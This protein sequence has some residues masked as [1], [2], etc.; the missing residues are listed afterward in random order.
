MGNESIYRIILKGLSDK[1][2]GASDFEKICRILIKYIYPCYSFDISE[3]GRGTQDGGYD[4]RDIQNNIKLAC[5]IEKTYKQKILEEIEKSKKNKDTRI[6]F[7]SNQL[8]PER[9]KQDICRQCKEKNSIEMEIFGIDFLSRKIESYL[10]EHPDV[11]LGNLLG[12]S[13][14]ITGERYNR[15]EIT[16]LDTEKIDVLYETKITINDRNNH[17]DSTLLACNDI[18]GENPL[19]DYIISKLQE[20]T[21]TDFDNILLSGI[22]GIGKSLLM[23][24]T[25]NKLVDE[26]SDSANHSKYSSIPYI[27]FQD[28]KYYHIGILKEKIKNNIECFMFFLDGLDEIPESTKTILS[29]E[30]HNIISENRKIKFVIAG[31]NA[32]FF[33]I[34]DID[35]KRLQIKKHIGDNDVEFY[36][37]LNRFEGTSI[38]DLL[39]VPIYRN[40]IRNHPDLQFN[41]ID[42]LYAALIKDKLESDKAKFDYSHGNTSRMPSVVNMLEVMKKLSYFCLN[43]F[44]ERRNVFSESEL[45]TSIGD[46]YFL[47]ILHSSI[48]DYNDEENINFISNFYYEYFVANAFCEAERKEIVSAFFLRRKIDISKLDIFVIFLNQ[49]KSKNR[50][51]YDFVIKKAM[52]DNIAYFLLCDFESL[53]DDDR[54]EAFIKILKTYNTKKEWIYYG[55]SSPSYSPLKNIDNMA[56]KMQELLPVSKQDMII[57][58]MAKNISKYLEHPNESKAIEFANN[59]TLLIPWTKNLWLPE[60]QKIL[61]G[62]SVPL[63]RFLIYHKYADQLPLKDILSYH[64][65]F[66][67]WYKDCGWTNKWG[68]TS[69]LE[70]MKN[71]SYRNYTLESEIIDKKEFIINLECF[72]NFYNNLLLRPLMVPLIK[73]AL[74]YR[75]KDAGRMVHT[76]SDTLDDDELQPIEF[77]HEAYTLFDIAKKME[78]TIAEILNV[79]LHAMNSDRY[80]IIKDEINSPVKTLENKL[81]SNLENIPDECFEQFRK[82]FFNFKKH[83]FDKNI[84]KKLFELNNTEQIEKLKIYLLGHILRNETT[85]H[86]WIIEQLLA[87]L[88]N[89]NKKNKALNCLNKIKQAYQDNNIGIYK[90]VIYY[91]NSDNSHIINKEIEDEYKN[92]FAEQIRLEEERKKTHMKIIQEIEESKQR[93]IDLLLDNDLMV[94]ELK[95]IDKYLEDHEEIEE[96]KKPLHKLYFI[97]HSGIKNRISYDGTYEPPPIF[98]ETAL[99]IIEDY[100]RSNQYSIGGIINHLSKNFFLE[101]YFY[102]YFYQ[103]YINNQKT[104]DDFDKYI[105]NILDGN[106][107]LKNKITSSINTDAKSRFDVET[108]GYFDGGANWLWA[109]PFLFFYK[110]FM[111]EKLFTWLTNRHILKFIAFINPNEIGVVMG[112][113]INIEWFTITFPQITH[114]EIV[115][116]GLSVI[117]DIKSPLARIQIVN[118]FILFYKTEIDNETNLEV[119]DFIIISTQKMFEEGNTSNQFSEY[120]TIS[121]FWRECSDD[122]IDRLFP[123]FH[124]KFILATIK[125][126]ENDIDYQYRNDILAYVIRI[127]NTDQKQKIICDIL[128]EMQ[129]YD[130][131]DDK[132]SSI[133]FFLACLGHEESIITVIN[134]YLEGIRKIAR[135]DPLF[136]L[137]FSCLKKTKSLLEKYLELY[138]YSIERNGELGRALHNL[139]KDGIKQHLMED[140]Y[141]IF[142]RKI[143]TQIRKRRKD[144]KWTEF[145]EEYLLQMEQIVFSSNR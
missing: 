53:P 96:E 114:N 122:H 41:N 46:S 140:N 9:E 106:K 115:N 138:I 28:L 81:F 30:I 55:R 124:I 133:I 116:C 125:K 84:L 132:S 130:A 119:F 5:S 144:N 6:I 97:R 47:F 63:I 67:C 105:S 19:M 13:I 129:N 23:K 66:Q 52:R 100:Y 59:L 142:E 128:N 56:Q 98:S 121:N 70:F 90:G 48:I 111:G 31:R 10:N 49:A 57:G 145:L 92:I 78:M 82:Y 72:N 43:L 61:Q 73:Y 62:I 26:F 79:I 95:K 103:F 44:L 32:S 54:Y 93:D 118:S 24:L 71:L 102:I 20:D 17:A 45:K 15:G 127:S 143:K 88:I 38:A 51:M 11:E 37:I 12:L 134:E 85:V 33:D 110:L 94:I 107:K 65:I 21:F 137:H 112:N 68:E 136:V 34:G 40:F 25:Y 77:D 18:I 80:E 16:A 126:S 86:S 74:S 60:Q 14:F 7:M 1:I 58:F 4:G 27:Q 101:K 104:I 139:A 141:Y 36:N 135:W 76:L 113:N 89:L 69:W 50:K 29:K 75:F 64:L 109:S 2:S 83:Y 131:T 123:I 120:L 39:P 42:E 8:I 91:I 99:H 108:I 87:G 117:D 22:G 35:G 3:G